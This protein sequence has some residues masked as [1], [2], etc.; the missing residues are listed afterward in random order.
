MRQE[1][2]QRKQ[3]SNEAV[4]DFSAD[5]RRQCQR[6][7]LSKPEWMHIFIQGLRTEIRSHIVLQ[8]PDTFEQA[9]HMAKLKEA[10]LKP[11]S[12]AQLSP[13]ALAQALISQLQ[14][15]QPEAPTVA[16]FSANTSPLPSTNFSP[17]PQREIPLTESAVRAIFQ[18][19]LRQAFRNNPNTP[20]GSYQRSDYRDNRPNYNNR[21]DNQFRNRRTPQGYPICNTCNRRGHTSYNCQTMM[22]QQRDPRLPREDRNM[23]NPTNR[24]PAQGN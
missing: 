13:N 9:E 15:P 19:E 12:Q 7:R 10:V 24:S 8:Q 11:D 20:R 1:L 23:Q 4:A 5:I 16:A 22:Q 2:T 6:L 14:K 18:Q 17:P 21:N 3:R